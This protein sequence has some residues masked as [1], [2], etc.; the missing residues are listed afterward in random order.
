MLLFSDIL[1]TLVRYASPSGTMCLRCLMFTLSGPVE[2]LCLICFIDACVVVSVMLVVCSF[3]VFLYIVYVCLMC[4]LCL[5]VLVN[6]FLM[7]LLCVW[8]K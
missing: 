6:C 8:V 2:F 1:Y 7:H 3:S 4:V 5:T